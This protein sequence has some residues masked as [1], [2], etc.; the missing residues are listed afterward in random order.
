MSDMSTHADAPR[1]PGR[2][3]SVRADEAIVQAT[4]DLLAEGSTIEALSI[5]AIAA[6]AGVGKATIYRRWSGKDALLLDALR[7]LK[8]TPPQPSGHSIRDDLVL[9]VGAIGHNIDP[10]AAKIMPC[11]VPEVNRSPV[12]YQL[13]QSMVEPRRKL[14]RQVLQ[15]GMRSGELRPD[16]DIELAMAL[17][18][19]PML[20]QRM[21]RWQPDLDDRLLPE[22]IVDAVLDG[23][24]VR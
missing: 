21:L 2:P 1:S 15:R 8:G 9:L 3:R 22:R 7:T 13:Y 17:L 23:L 12:H 4:L 6:R 20:M 5:E 18:S 10:R 11:L 19:G 16:V 14:M 24:R